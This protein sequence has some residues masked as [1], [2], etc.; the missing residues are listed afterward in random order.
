MCQIHLSSWGRKS[1]KTKIQLH[2]NSEFTWG[3]GHKVIRKEQ[4]KYKEKF[5]I[6]INCSKKLKRVWTIPFGWLREENAVEKLKLDRNE[7]PVTG[8]AGARDSQEL[9]HHP[10]PC[11][12]GRQ[13][14]WKKTEEPDTEATNLGEINHRGYLGH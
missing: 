7:V 1:H 11:R 10:E 3:D 5:N 8:E 2:R 4:M 6:E 9:E 12:R 13:R 14:T